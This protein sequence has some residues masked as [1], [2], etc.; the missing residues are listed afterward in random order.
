MKILH[1]DIFWFF[2]RD[3]DFVSRTITEGSFDLDKFPASRVRQLVKKLESS[4]ATACNIKQVAS[5]PQ[6]TQ[7]NL[8]WHQRTEHPTTRHSKKRRS[9]NKQ[10][11]AHHKAPENQVT[12]QVKKHY[13]NRTVHKIKVRCNKCGN[14]THIKGF[15]CPAKKYQCKLCHKY[16]HFSSLCY[17]KKIQAHHKSNIRN[18]KAHQLKAG[19]VY[20]HNSSMCSHSSES[21]SSE[22]FCLQLQVQCNHVEDKKIPNPVHLIT[23]IADRLK[24]HHNRN[25]YVLVSKIRHVC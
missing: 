11:Q 25:K 15:H 18:P 10:R 20:T 23:N 9:M 16:G 7:M 19:P 17:Q 22:S 1:Q 13:N 21:S 2:L 3:E 4:E 8:L 6:V 5:D 12:G 24:P 14:S